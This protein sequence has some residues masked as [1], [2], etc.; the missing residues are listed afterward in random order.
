[1]ASKTPCTYEVYSIT[2]GERNQ[3]L[4]TTNRREAMLLYAHL[5]EG[6]TLPRLAINGRQLTIEEAAKYNQKALGQRVRLA[7]RPETGRKRYESI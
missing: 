6:G 4:C 2:C 7:R 5:C 1:M 3:Y